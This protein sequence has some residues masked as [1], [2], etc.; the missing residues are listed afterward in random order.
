[1]DHPSDLFELKDCE[2]FIEEV[3]NFGSLILT[4]WKSYRRLLI[5]IFLMKLEIQPS[6]GKG[7]LQYN[8]E[9]VH[10]CKVVFNVQKPT[11]EPLLNIADYFCWSIQRVF[12]R[13]E[14]RYYDY[15]SKKISVVWDLYDFAGTLN[16]QNYYSRNRKLTENNCINEK[17]PKMH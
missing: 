11:I 9:R 8:L 2:N 17:S 7:R 15:M 13:G 1:M 14:T 10:N 5:I 12:E 6:M 4:L 16:G 3:I